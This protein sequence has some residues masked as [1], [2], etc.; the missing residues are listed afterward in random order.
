[1]A[2]MPRRGGRAVPVLKAIRPDA[3]HHK[4]NTVMG[5]SPNPG[6]NHRVVDQRRRVTQSRADG[7]SQK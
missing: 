3:Q 2:T 5:L 1:M 4:I 7:A 6:V